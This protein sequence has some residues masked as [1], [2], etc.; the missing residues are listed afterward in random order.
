MELWLIRHGETLWNR[1][2]RAQGQLDV[3]LSPLGL[4]QA[5]K[6]AVRLQPIKFDALIS[7]DLS[8][9]Y[10]TAEIVASRLELPIRSDVAWREIHMG[11]GQGATYSELFVHKHIRPMTEPWEGGE[12]KRDVMNRVSIAL[13]K[14]FAEFSGSRVAVFSHGGAI[15]GAIHVLLNDLEQHIDFAERGNTSISKLEV[16]A[17]NKGR[18]LVY[19]DTAHLEELLA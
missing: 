18:L 4:E 17:G 13:E 2:Q 6:L 7:S 16:K 3:P 1:E 19:N 8:R 10:Q 11:V 12:S 15:R 5:E 14:L 9:A